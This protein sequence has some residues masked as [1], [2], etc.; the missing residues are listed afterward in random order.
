[1]SASPPDRVHRRAHFS[2][3]LT[4]GGAEVDAPEQ[5][6][7][8][9]AR[10]SALAH[11]RVAWLRWIAGWFVIALGILGVILPGLPALVLI[12]LGVAL[13]GR[14]STFVRW[15]R[16]RMKLLLRVAETWRGVPGRVGRILRE[17]ER[18]LATFLRARRIGTW[19]RPRSG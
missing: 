19:E 12:P 17:R 10:R 4:G 13:V 8:R 18:R 1:M 14:R 7:R 6:R 9:G 2:R 3:L 5:R 15:S 16:T 11:P